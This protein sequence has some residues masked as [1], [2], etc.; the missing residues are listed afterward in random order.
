MVHRGVDGN[1]A[2]AGGLFS[3]NVRTNGVLAGVAGP[4]RR[5][6][7][8]LAGFPD[9]S[10]TIEDMFSAHDK[11]ITRLVG[12]GT[13]TRFI[14]GRQGDRQ[15]GTGPRLCRLAFRRRPGGEDL[16]DTGSVRASKADGI[17]PE[18]SMR[19]S[20]RSLAAGRGTR[21]VVRILRGRGAG[22]VLISYILSSCRL[23]G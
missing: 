16:Y 4:K 23:G 21:Q 12:R 13:H 10:T 9:L 22:P 5:I 17:F 7:E 1:V 6:Q 15:A 19:R 3:E 20:P 2:L 11:I 14:W 18:E 8:W